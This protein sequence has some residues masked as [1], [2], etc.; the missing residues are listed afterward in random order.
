MKTKV[1]RCLFAFALLVTA[2]VLQAQEI[3]LYGEVRD[4]AT[5]EPVIGANVSVKG[6]S[7]GT[8]TDVDGNFS[9]RAVPGAELVFSCI[10]YED[11]I[12]KVKA[13]QAFVVIAMTA[14]AVM[15]E[16]TVVVGYG[17][18]KK[19]SSVGSIST[20]KGEDLEKA[21]RVNS[22]SE[23]L[24]GQLAGVVSIS[25]NSKP[26]S[27]AASIFIRGKATW[28]SA[29]PLVLVDGIERDFNDVDINEVESI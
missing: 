5:G 15:L 8:S 29:A 10:G 20:A 11:E 18:Q 14:D 24:Q 4:D 26:G 13:G 19:A 27:D 16:E 1:F 2:Q 3:I 23:A 9:L 28:G 21:T 25:S 7:T 6:S 12:F 17:Q 22:V